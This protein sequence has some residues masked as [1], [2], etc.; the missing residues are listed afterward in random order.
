MFKHLFLRQYIE[1]GTL[2]NLSSSID[3][4][5]YYYLVVARYLVFKLLFVVICANEE[6]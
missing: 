3:P 1:L 6:I 4:L 5:A 2:N